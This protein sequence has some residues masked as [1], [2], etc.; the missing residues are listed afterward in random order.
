MKTKTILPPQFR[1]RAAKIMVDVRNRTCIDDDDAEV[2]A[3]ILQAELEEF[4]L[5]LDEYYDEEYCVAVSSARNKAY[6]AGYDD[7]YSD[8]HSAV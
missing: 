3:D 6:D 7:G 5:M 4:Y 8:G 2:L 1:D